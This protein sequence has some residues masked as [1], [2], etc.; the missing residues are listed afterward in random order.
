[1]MIGLDRPLPGKAIFHDL[2]EVRF[3]SGDILPSIFPFPRV[4]RKPCQSAEANGW[5]NNKVANKVDIFIVISLE[6]GLGFRCYRL[7]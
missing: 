1:M 5:I 2:E 6:R 3:R 4:P 7:P